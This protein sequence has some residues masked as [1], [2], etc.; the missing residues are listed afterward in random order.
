MFDASLKQFLW[1]ES[2]TVS[3]SCGMDFSMYPFDHHECFMKLWHIGSSNNALLDEPEIL[4]EE[5]VIWQRSSFNISFEP[6]TSITKEVKTSKVKFNETF[7]LARIK[8]E[9]TRKNQEVWS[10]F[11]E[12]WFYPLY[13]FL[14]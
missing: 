5:E 7:S 2:F 11:I 9:L 8:I 3:V 12:F 6:M 10:V 1:V 14:F 13:Y 4:I